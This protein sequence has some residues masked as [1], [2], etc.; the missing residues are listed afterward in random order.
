MLLKPYCDLASREHATCGRFLAFLMKT[1]L[2]HAVLFQ[3]LN[4]ERASYL[5][6]ELF[7]FY[8]SWERT[9]ASCQFN[10]YMLMRPFIQEMFLIYYV[11]VF[12][13]VQHCHLTDLMTDL[14]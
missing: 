8:I 5:Q 2:T 10:K 1:A 4:D 9:L 11:N 14:I 13:Y 12:Y 7:F 3:N 6:V